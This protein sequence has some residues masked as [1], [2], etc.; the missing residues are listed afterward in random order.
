M[1]NERKGIVGTFFDKKIKP[2]LL[3]V[4]TIGAVLSAIAY[5]IIIITMIFGLT[6]EASIKDTVIFACVNAVIGFAIMQFLKIQGI[7]FAKNMPE[8]QE[9]LKTYRDLN[10]PKDKRKHSLRYFWISSVIKDVLT[11]ALLIVITTVC[12]IYLVIKGTHD[13][14]YLLLMIVNL[15]MF[16]CFGLISL[17]NAHDFYL[18]QHV[19]YL[20]EQINETRKKQE[21]EEVAKREA[22]ERLVMDQEEHLDKRDDLVCPNCRTG[23][24]ESSDSVW[25]TCPDCRQMVLVRGSELYCILGSAVHAGLDD[26]ICS[27]VRA[28]ESS[29]EN[30]TEETEK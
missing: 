6:V 23:I 22:E 17:V 29:R 3:Y 8:N 25:Y 18:E 11:R 21:A 9:L 5:I 16:A 19:P 14:T 2:V 26:T 7:T 20:E 13:Y 24:L 28:E 4:G 15:L 10:P 1:D 30:K 12:I 27:D